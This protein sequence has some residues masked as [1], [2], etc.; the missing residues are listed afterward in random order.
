MKKHLNYFSEKERRHEERF[1][2]LRTRWLN[3]I[4]RILVDVGVTAN[5]ISIIGFLMIFGF[6]YFIEINPMMAFIFLVLHVIID[7]L[8]GPVARISKRE[9]NKGA[10]LDIICDHTGIVVA[11]GGLIYFDLVNGVIGLAYIYLYTIM[12]I[13]TIIRNVMRISSRMVLRTKY[14][15]YILFGIYVFW[16]IN[17]LDAAMVLFSLIMII[18][19]INDFIAIREKLK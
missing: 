3:P 8:D 10:F 13:F 19:T 16:E 2:Y 12:I 7:G 14:F 6:V 17:Y 5:F 4:A 1:K 11:I 9:G 15:V 18:S